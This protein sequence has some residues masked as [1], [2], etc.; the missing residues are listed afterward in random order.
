V[1]NNA[2]PATSVGTPLIIIAGNSKVNFKWKALVVIASKLFYLGKNDFVVDTRSMF[3]GAK[4]TDKRVQY[5][6]D[7]SPGVSHF[8]YFE[9]EATRKALLLALQNT[10]ET[11][12]PGFTL[13]DQR[14]F[15]DE[16]VRA[17]GLD[18][19][20]LFRNEVT[21]KKP[22]VVLLPGIMG[23]NLSVKDETVWINYF[24]FLKEV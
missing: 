2:L 16:D 21:G 14:G 12:I 10:G 13:L 7:E 20:K 11:L 6:L 3:N 24:G 19:G 9:N 22:I 4:R 23:S 1:L 18:S 17:F 8:N 5:F 15:T